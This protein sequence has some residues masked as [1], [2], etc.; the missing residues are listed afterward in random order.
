M[1]VPTPICALIASRPSATPPSLQPTATHT[2]PPMPTPNLAH[3]ASRLCHSSLNWLHKAYVTTPHGTRQPNH[4]LLSLLQVANRPLTKGESCSFTK[5]A[6][7]KLTVRASRVRPPFGSHSPL[8]PAWVNKQVA[9]LRWALPDNWKETGSTLGS[10]LQGWG[11]LSSFVLERERCRPQR[12]STGPQTMDLGLWFQ[13][14]SQLWFFCLIHMVKLKS[15]L[16]L[17]FG[18]ECGETG[19]LL[20]VLS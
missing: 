5:A 2:M 7:T 12:V 4:S 1:A 11:T 20:I 6:S 17:W 16:S 15:L 10:N 19:S 14:K 13:S 18:E 9:C 3:T 8:P